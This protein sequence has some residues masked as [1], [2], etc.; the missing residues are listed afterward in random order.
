MV[1]GLKGYTY[2][3]K[4]R[5]LGMLTLEERSHQADMAQTFK[6][7]RGEWTTSIVT[8]GSRWWIRQGG[9]QE[10]LMTH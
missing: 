10:V 2:E 9:L 7:I 4:L 3:D 8:V 6:I 5:E 1:S